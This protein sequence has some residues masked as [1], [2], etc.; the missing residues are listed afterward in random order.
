MCLTV[1]KERFIP[2]VLLFYTNIFLLHST[3][4]SIDYF[5]IIYFYMIFDI[6]IYNN[7]NGLPVT[8]VPKLLVLQ[9]INY[10]ATFFLRKMGLLIFVY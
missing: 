5:Y 10:G 1:K 2:F 9:S 6:T 4:W 8:K 3:T 7:H